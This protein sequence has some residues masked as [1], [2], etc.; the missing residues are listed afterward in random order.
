MD[1]MNSEDWLDRQLREA[2]PYV[3][4]NG[5]TGRVLRNLP[6]PRR[7]RESLRTLI[8]LGSAAFASALAYILSDGGRFIVVALSRLATV[9][10]LW[11]LALTVGSGI[12]VMTG[13]IVAALS[14]TSRVES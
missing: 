6:A 7:R 1:Q 12:L 10:T 5:F 9:S 8:L 4:D 13:G 11:L 2:A 14:K 3:E